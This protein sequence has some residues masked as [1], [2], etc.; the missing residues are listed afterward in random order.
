MKIMMM[1]NMMITMIIVIRLVEACTEVTYGW[2]RAWPGT[3]RA[4]DS[5][6]KKELIQVKVHLLLR[7]GFN[8]QKNGKAKVDKKIPHTGDK[9]SLDRCG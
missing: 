2:M 8:K 3:S 6:K 7:E 9:E 4:V 1:M 5:T